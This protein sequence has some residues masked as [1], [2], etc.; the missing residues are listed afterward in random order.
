M[1]LV[2]E[3]RLLNENNHNGQQFSKISS[4]IT[5]EFAGVGYFK[6]RPLF[7]G[8]MWLVVGISEGKKE[9]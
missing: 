2:V 5:F 6:T 4:G 3:V 9:S 8:L 1:E 7:V